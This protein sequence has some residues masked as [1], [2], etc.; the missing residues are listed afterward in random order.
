MDSV[1][2]SSRLANLLNEAKEAGYE[3]HQGRDTD[4]FEFY[5]DCGPLAKIEYQGSGPYGE[6]PGRWVWGGIE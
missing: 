1:D 2:V 6:S 3:I 4:Y 5:D